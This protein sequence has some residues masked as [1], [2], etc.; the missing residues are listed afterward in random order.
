M[1]YILNTEFKMD[2]EAILQY[3]EESD[4]IISNT[5]YSLKKKFNK[6]ELF[7]PSW[8]LSTKFE[9]FSQLNIDTIENILLELK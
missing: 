2:C 1:I 5:V 8:W 6:G 7:E 3:F 4:F 9:N